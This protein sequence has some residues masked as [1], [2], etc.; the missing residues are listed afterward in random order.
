MVHGEA[1]IYLMK[2]FKLEPGLVDIRLGFR[3]CLSVI[4]T[5]DKKIPKFLSDKF[6]RFFSASTASNAFPV[7]DEKIQIYL[8]IKSPSEAT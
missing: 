3:L 8:K 2:A 1:L 6:F 5:T 4:Q 7:F